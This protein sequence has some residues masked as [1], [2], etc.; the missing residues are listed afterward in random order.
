MSMG[1]YTAQQLGS[2]LIND[3][4]DFVRDEVDIDDV[5]EK[6]TIKEYAANQFEPEEVYGKEL[7]RE[8]ALENGFVE[9]DADSEKAAS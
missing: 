2:R 7:L 1:N 5:Y 3:V 6:D 9:Y 4:I 8:W